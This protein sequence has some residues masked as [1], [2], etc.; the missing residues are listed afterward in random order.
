L[1]YHNGFAER[2]G[3]AVRRAEQFFELLGNDA[4][5]RLERLADGTNISLLHVTTSDVAAWTKRLISHG[6]IVLPPRAGVLRV[7][8]D[9]NETLL[10]G[11]PEEIAGVFHAALM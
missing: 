6:I 3:E 11:S 5:F 8:L 7:R 1:H 10:R 4:R 9:T 2:F